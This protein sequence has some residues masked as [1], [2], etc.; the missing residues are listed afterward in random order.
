[1]V[2]ACFLIKIFLILPLACCSCHTAHPVMKIHLSTTTIIHSLL[3]LL[4]LAHFLT[5]DHAL[6]DRTDRLFTFLCMDSKQSPDTLTNS[7]SALHL[8]LFRNRESQICQQN[9]FVEGQT[10]YNS[11]QKLTLHCRACSRYC[12]IFTQF[13]DLQLV[14]LHLEACSIN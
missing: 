8:G 10:I 11:S 5:D 12:F 1:M 7:T 6:R 2:S 14:E 9:K 13:V 3:L 4:K